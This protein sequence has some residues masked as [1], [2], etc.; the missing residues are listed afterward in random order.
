FHGH[1]DCG[2]PNL[3]SLRSAQDLGRVLLVAGS[4]HPTLRFAEEERDG[5]EVMS[6]HLSVAADS[7]HRA[8][9]QSDRDAAVRDIMRAA[10]QA[11]LVQF[12]EELDQVASVIEID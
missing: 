6:V 9:R 1:A 2:R 3:A 12:E 5:V 8:L 7:A 11:A 10:Q 4:D